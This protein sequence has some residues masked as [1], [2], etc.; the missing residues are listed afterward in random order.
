M[1]LGGIRAP[2]YPS[3]LHALGYSDDDLEA[4]PRD[5]WVIGGEKVSEDDVAAEHLGWYAH[6]PQVV[7]AGMKRHERLIGAMKL[8]D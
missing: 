6:F 8:L 7:A 5:H 4:G 2:I 1:L 3:T